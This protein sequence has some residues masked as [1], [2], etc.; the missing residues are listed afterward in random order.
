MSSRDLNPQDDDDGSLVFKSIFLLMV[1]I[2]L[3]FV[4]WIF[5]SDYCQPA[6]TPF[7]QT[8]FFGILFLIFIEVIMTGWGSDDE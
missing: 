5:I 4:G 3:G 2:V 1:L 8:V 6:P 7:Q